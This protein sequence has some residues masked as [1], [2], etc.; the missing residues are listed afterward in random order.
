M[1][2]WARLAMLAALPDL[3]VRLQGRGLVPV[4]LGQMLGG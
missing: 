2:W 3:L 1:G 4:T